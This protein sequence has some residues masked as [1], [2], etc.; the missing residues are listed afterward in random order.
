M[1]KVRARRRRR[2]IMMTATPILRTVFKFFWGSVS[3]WG[4]D[5][6]ARRKAICFLTASGRLEMFSKAWVSRPLSC[7]SVF[8][9]I[10]SFW[11]V[12]SSLLLASFK[13]SWEEEIFWRSCFKASLIDCDTDWLICSRIS[14]VSAILCL[15]CLT[16]SI[17]DLIWFGPRPWSLNSLMSLIVSNI[18]AG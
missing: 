13:G 2:I 11:A 9:E 4:G 6:E 7:S 1:R 10:K 15:F 12:V 14:F 8:W 5:W 3:S 16:S 17:F 18:S